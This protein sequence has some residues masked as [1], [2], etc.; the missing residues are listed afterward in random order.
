MWVLDEKQMPKEVLALFA[1]ILPHSDDVYENEKDDYEKYEG[2]EIYRQFYPCFLWK[3]YRGKYD[4]YGKSEQIEHYYL[5]QRVF[6]K[7]FR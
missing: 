3:Y 4:I 5:M 2:E 1:N 6:S 7:I